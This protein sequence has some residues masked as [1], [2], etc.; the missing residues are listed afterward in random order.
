MTTAH[1]RQ[2]IITIN[3]TDTQLLE[4]DFAPRCTSCNPVDCLT[5]S[6]GNP[7]QSYVS[8]RAT[9]RHGLRST[10]SN[11]TGCN[12]RSTDN[13][14]FS[15]PTSLNTVIQEAPVIVSD[16]AG[17]KFTFLYTGSYR[18]DYSVPT[19][20]NA[21]G[22]GLNFNISAVISSASNPAGPGYQSCFASG[23]SFRADRSVVVSSTNLIIPN[24]NR[25]D[26]LTFRYNALAQSFGI[27]APRSITP[28]IETGGGFSVA[29]VR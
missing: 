12:S 19:H 2:T 8:R 23:N 13:V 11:L 24:V 29:L 26:I 7:S 20:T 15:V 5:C 22:S 17:E 25:G 3:T 9:A 4:R 28:V 6:P 14:K 16:P 21:D 18:I 27:N 1:P 10:V